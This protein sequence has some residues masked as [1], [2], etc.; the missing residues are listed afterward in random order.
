M[1]R[2]I[3]KGFAP[4]K[5]ILLGSHAR[6]DARDDSDVD[7]LMLFAEVEN[8]RERARD[9][10]LTGTSSTLCIGR[11]LVRAEFFMSVPPEVLGGS[12]SVGPKGGA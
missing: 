1:V 11:P 7:L 8:P 4:D 12:P 9:S 5:I 2:R 6:G 3:A 10:S